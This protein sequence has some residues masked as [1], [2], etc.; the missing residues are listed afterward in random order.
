M[1]N[2]QIIQYIPLFLIVSSYSFG[3]ACIQLGMWPWLVNVSWFQMLLSASLLVYTYPDGD[4]N[5]IL[6]YFV[7][8]FIVGFLVEV[9]GINTGVIFGE[10]TYGDVLGWKI[11]GTPPVIGVN[12][13]LVT[14]A[15]N[16]LVDI[17]KLNKISH[18]S[19]AATLITSLDYLIEPDAI[20]LGMWTW[21]EETI[22][23]KNYIAWWVV[24]FG[25][26][27]YYTTFQFQKHTFSYWVIGLMTLFFLIK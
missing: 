17:V 13:F 9:L 22:P 11:L 21:V 5:H 4:R 1:K 8:S 16:Q 23:I 15:I 19:I 7:V 10:Y 12:W 6:R 24:S 25:L 3:I 20:R 18:A 2:K 14:Y 26:S 27:Y